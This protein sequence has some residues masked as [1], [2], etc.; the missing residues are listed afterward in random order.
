MIESIYFY[1]W[2][3]LS[4]TLMAICLSLIAPFLQ[5]RRQTLLVF[6]YSQI[7]VV[8][9][10]MSLVLNMNLSKEVLAIFCAL[11]CWLGAYFFDIKSSKNQSIFF[12]TSFVALYCINQILISV[13]PH[14]T[15]YSSLH[16]SGDLITILNDEAKY[17]IFLAVVFL[18]LLTL[19]HKKILKFSFIR[20]IGLS[21]Q[22]QSINSRFFEFSLLLF[23]YYIISISTLYFGFL[24]TV[25][26][27][28]ISI[29]VPT[30]LSQ[31]Y[32]GNFFNTLLL[33]ATVLPTSFYLS[34]KI[35]YITVPTILLSF[36][37]AI[38]L[39]A[40]LRLAK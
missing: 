33:V 18:I 29:I 30:Y 31:S 15:A 9:L 8:V 6:S 37:I 26:I 4:G 16:N 12:A 35:N 17:V 3:I 36:L 21:F 22:N 38:V 25:G 23:F 32:L 19:G 10:L 13:F 28:F 2:S 7:A 39:C 11:L 1:K 27:M 40:T 24:F 5:S 34:V 14:L 20:S